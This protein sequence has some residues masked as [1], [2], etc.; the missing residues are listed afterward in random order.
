MIEQ[1]MTFGSRNKLVSLIVLILISVVLGSGLPSLKIDTSYDSLISEKDPGWPGY[2]ETIKEFGSDNTTIVYIEDENLWQEN[3][4]L[5]IEDAAYALEDLD[6]VEKVESLFSV[7]NIR[8]KEGSLDMG[9]IMSETP[10]DQKGI[11][12]A[13]DNALYSPLIRNNFIS[14]DGNKTAINITVSRDRKDPEFNIEFFEKVEEILVPLRGEVDVVFQVGPPRLNVEIEKGMFSDMQLLSPI[15]TLILVGTIIFFLRTSTAAIIPIATATISILWTFGFMGHFGLPL[16]LLTAIVPSLVIVIG[17]TEDT[18][19]LSAYLHGVAKDGDRK[20]AIRYMAKHVGLPI[21][22]TSFTT[23]VGFGSNG[24][25]DIPLI[26]DFAYATSFAMIANLVCTVLVVP[27]LLSIIGPKKTVI[28]TKEGAEAGG[29]MGLITRGFL[30]LV[31][32]QR[33]LVMSVTAIVVAFFAY[34][35]TTIKVS[36]DPLSYFKSSHPIVEDANI[37]HENLAGMQI[38]YLTLEKKEDDAF[39][40]PENLAMLDDLV[41]FMRSQQS[42]DKVISITDYFSLVNQEMNSSDPDFYRVPETRQLAEQYLLMFQRSDVER[43]LSADNRKA[44][45][46]V[47]HN[48][49]ESSELNSYLDGVDKYLSSNLLPGT[50]YQF[51]GENLMINRAAESLFS[52]Q[53]ESLAILLAIIFVIIAFL[54]SSPLGGLVSLGPN[55]FPVVL[56]FGVMGLLDIPLNP[57]TATV[58]AIAVGIAIDDTTHLFTRYKDECLETPD[59]DVAVRKTVVAESVPVISTSISLALGFGVLFF[60]NFAIV[61]QFGILAAMT[62]V[63]AMLADLLLTPIILRKLRLVSVF[64]ML[65]IT[66]QDRLTTESSIFRFMSKSQVKRVILLSQIESVEANQKI[67]E[68]NTEGNFM[69]VV[70]EGAFEV[71]QPQT[72]GSAPL[73][74]L[75]PGDVFGEVGYLG[76]NKRT[77]DVVSTENGKVLK[78]TA[79][80]VSKSLRF[81]PRT[82]ALFNEN[83]ARVLA[84]RMR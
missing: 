11:D 20:K 6:N 33:V 29:L 80:N 54:F 67:I 77:A 25:N 34:H 32:N 66:V 42:Y 28:A 37:L 71:Y 43:Y 13:R 69:Y 8:D 9:K 31:E 64:D 27:L 24:I 55:A 41:Q 38:F 45:I 21:F 65:K 79:D 40:N 78:I 56:N 44:N 59:N 16:T 75:G 70:V 81:F 47:R 73:A 23:A 18:H 3:K 22:I 46:L 72:A 48:M 7:L 2:R 50:K 19:L 76:A 61:M 62:M 26:R 30:Y 4:L 17:S 39:L 14:I 57:G 83:I 74:K 58:A 35:A 10:F 51:S 53:V 60:S 68:H 84:S 12:Q 1:I 5:A 82:A 36:N 52:G 15:S 49:S 63:Y